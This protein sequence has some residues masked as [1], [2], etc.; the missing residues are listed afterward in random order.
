MYLEYLWNRLSRDWRSVSKEEAANH[1]YYGLR[2]WLLFF[3]VAAAYSAITCSIDLISPHDGK[4]FG[5]FGERPGVIR[6]VLLI[7]AVAQLPILILGPLKNRL[8]P[9]LWIAGMWITAIAY[10]VAYDMP[11]R[12]DLMILSVAS[13]LVTA[14][15]VT[16]YALHSKRVNVTFHHRVPASESAQGADVAAGN[17]PKPQF[18][19]RSQR[20][21]RIFWGL[22]IFFAVAVAFAALLP[23][24]LGHSTG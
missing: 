13:T 12:T 21:S 11:G 5:T 1:R 3:Y 15:L 14:A 6:A 4:Y 9:M 22:A 24:L 19:R 23:H 18:Y 20:S 10:I 8:M 16:W 7:G 2:G 17:M